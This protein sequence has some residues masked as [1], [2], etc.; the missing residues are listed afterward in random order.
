MNKS[1]GVTLAFVL[2][3]AGSVVADEVFGGLPSGCYANATSVSQSFVV[4]NSSVGTYVS[5]WGVQ[6][7][8]DYGMSQ[9]INKFDGAGFS[10]FA[11]VGGNKLGCKMEKDVIS[12]FNWNGVYFSVE[13]N[14]AVVPVKNCDGKLITDSLG[15]LMC[16]VDKVGS[17]SG[18]SG[19]CPSNWKLVV[20]N[21]LVVACRK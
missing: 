1:V 19:T 16:G 10:V 2:L 18:W 17:V 7:Q 14:S 5:K 6:Y 4:G 21:G 3:M 12:C 15:R 9:F 8:Q 13:S 20:E 11:N